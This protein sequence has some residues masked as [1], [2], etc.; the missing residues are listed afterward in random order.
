MMILMSLDCGKNQATRK[1]RRL[2][3][4]NSQGGIVPK[5]GI[6]CRFVAWTPKT[7]SILP[8]L[9]WTLLGTHRWLYEG[10]KSFTP[11]PQNIVF[12]AKKRP[13][14]AQNW[15]FWPN[16]GIFGPF[17]RMP[18]QNTMRTSCLG[19]S[20]V[21]WVPKLLLTPVK[22]RIFGSKTAKFG[23]KLKFLAKY[24]HFWPI[25]FGGRQKLMQ[26]RCLGGFFCYM[27]TKTVTYSSKN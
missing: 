10:T 16:N 11:S 20:S 23:P 22:I 5:Y 3:I 8:K 15:H 9:G 12:L 1:K 18:D 13:N 25:W 27:G 26:T 19:G 2:C 4:L 21:I 14:L 6:F 7:G 17:G 24:R